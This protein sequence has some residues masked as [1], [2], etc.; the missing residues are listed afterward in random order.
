MSGWDWLEKP[1]ST[2][3]WGFVARVIVK[4][5]VLFVALNLVY[6]ALNPLMSPAAGVSL[7][8]A[9]LPYRTRLPYGDDPARDYNVSSDS[10]PAM[11]A[12]HRISQPK[13]ADEF[14]VIV[15]GD[16]ATW[17]WFLHPDE[18]YAAAISAAAAT[19]ADGRRIVAYNL[20]YPIMSLMKDALLLDAVRDMQPDMIVWL[21][22]L[23]SFPRDKQLFPPLVQA[24]A[25]RVRRLIADYDIA[26][27]A[28]D[29]RLNV[30]D[31]WQ[32]TI[33]AQRRDIADWLR[34][35][36]YGFSWAATGIDQ[37][38]PPDIP[39]R[40]SD[41]DADESWDAYDAATTLTADDLA[42]DVIAAGDALADVPLLIVNEPIFISDGQN[43]DLRYNSWYPRW[44][45][46]QYRELLAEEA[47]RRGWAL[48]DLWD[49]LPPDAFTDSPVHLSPNG[50][51]LLADELL[52]IITGATP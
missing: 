36:A 38:I 15:L 5:A 7:Y 46:D 52:A 43:S 11:I 28:D 20:G 35:Q 1:D 13:A 27:D 2:P 10:I 25:P 31:F 48:H 18:T 24:N 33:V 6:A 4:A 37:Y 9:A 21:V 50:S 51:R 49:A 14:R 17:G 23:Q 32:R 22:T 29:A 44:A 45:Y 8:G 42:F 47:D 40:E 12:S 34:L 41:F 26:L 3:T 39:L 30:P 19:T 16:S